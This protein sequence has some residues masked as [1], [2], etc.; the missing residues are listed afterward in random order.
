MTKVLRNPKI[1]VLFEAKV[2]YFYA[3]FW[4]GSWFLPAAWTK[5]V[6]PKDLS[7]EGKIDILSAGGK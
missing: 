5:K 1:G 6:F 3:D 4:V 2:Q 7:K